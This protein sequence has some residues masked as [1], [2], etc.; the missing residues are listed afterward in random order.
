MS[1]NTKLAKPQ[2]TNEY[3]NVHC[4]IQDKDGNIWLVTTGEGVYRHDGKEFVQFTEKDGLSNNSVWSIIEDRSGNIWFA[5]D[6]G[7]SR[8]DGKTISKIPFIITGSTAFGTSMLQT[9]KN[10]VWSIFQDR[11]GT[12]WLASD[13]G[14]YCYD[15]KAFAYFLD[16]AGSK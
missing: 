4:I 10:I 1:K 5:T 13:R 15:G 6:D 14:I 11:K 9:G 3:Q 7:I 2:G 8:Y 16:N 12:I